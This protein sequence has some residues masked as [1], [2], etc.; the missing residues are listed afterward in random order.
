M[1]TILKALSLVVLC[2]ITA[3]ISGCSLVLPQQNDE[4][5]DALCG[6]FM[7]FY[8][9]EKAITEEDFS[10][11]EAIKIYFGKHYYT[12]EPDDFY[13][14]SVDGRDVLSDVVI[15]YKINKL[16]DVLTGYDVSITASLPHTEALTEYEMHTYG[17]FFD[18]VQRSYYTSDLNVWNAASPLNST[19]KTRTA[20]F[21]TLR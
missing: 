7:V 3:G 12:E 8:D 2:A 6:L 15:N 9:D 11:D 17:I 13:W 16:D 4:D 1:N 21:T 10:N 19:T 5:K 18:D 20:C 14:E